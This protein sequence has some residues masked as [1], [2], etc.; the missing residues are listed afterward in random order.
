MR[1]F[2][3]QAL[4]GYAMGLSQQNLDGS[5]GFGALDHLP[6]LKVLDFMMHLLSKVE[7]AM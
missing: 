6:P 2:G 5:L 1:N 4:L 3:L 7:N